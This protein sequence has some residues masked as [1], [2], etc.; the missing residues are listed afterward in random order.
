M[1]LNKNRLLRLIKLVGELKENRYPNSKTFAKKLKESDLYEETSIE[2]CYKTIQRD[3]KALKEEF[4]APIGY[5]FERQGYYLKHHGWDFNY[6]VIPD[7]MLMPSIFGAKIAEDTFPEPLK[8]EIRKA[9]NMQLT[10]NNPEFLETAALNT[11]MTYSHTKVKINPDVFKAIFTAWQKH[12]SV[13]ITY[14]PDPKV[15]KTI[16]VVDP[17]IISF[18]GGAWYVKAFCHLRDGIRTFAV[19]RIKSAE[20]TDYTYE[21]PKEVLKNPQGVPFNDEGIKDI[22]LWCSPEIA[23]YIMERNCP[24]NQTYKL[25]PDGSLNLYI[26]SLTSFTLTRWILGEAGNIKVIKPESLRVDIIKMAENILKVYNK[27]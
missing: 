2:C 19:H 15:E 18:Y 11:F 4:G 14:Q 7:N 3:I 13:K 9:V 21:V 10:A 6:P 23:C 22:E 16:R 26:K 24:D 20:L 27:E 25:N 12:R 1:G 5:D 8:S 17:Y